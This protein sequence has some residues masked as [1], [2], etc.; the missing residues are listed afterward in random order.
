ML[1]VVAFAYL[2]VPV[3]IFLFSFLSLPFVAISAV[4]LALLVH[5]IYNQRHEFPIS[6]AIKDLG[7]YW[8]LLLMVSVFT[9]FTFSFPLYITWPRTHMLLYELAVNNWSPIVEIGDQS[10]TTRYYVGWYIVPTLLAKLFGIQFLSL[11][12]IL[13]TIVGLFLT[14]VLAFN[15]Y[16]KAKSLLIAGSVFFLLSGLDILMHGGNIS[17]Y[18]SGGASDIDL[19]NRMAIHYPSRLL[20]STP[21][22][23][24]PIALS[25]C[26]YLYHRRLATQ[27]S[28]VIMLFTSMWSTQ[29]ALGLLPIAAWA[30]FKE[31][32]ESWKTVFSWQNLLVAPLLLLPVFLYLTQQ[33]PS[34][35]L[36]FT[37]E[38]EEFS[39]PA[40]LLL[41]IAQFL[42]ILSLLWFFSPQYR[43]LLLVFG[44]FV[45]MPMLVSYGD[46]WNTLIDYLPGSA[47]VIITVLAAKS[48]LEKQSYRSDILLLY[49][50]VAALG[51]AVYFSAKF[52]LHN[53]EFRSKKTAQEF[54]SSMYK[55]EKLL[56]KAGVWKSVPNWEVHFFIKTKNARHV[57]GIPVMRLSDTN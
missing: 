16:N 44:L 35:P 38:W 23:L 18:F 12:A 2:G 5:L 9:V 42:I 41:Y 25:A 40:L 48:Y 21:S 3:F 1:F 22:H 50:L 55:R 11:F 6:P 24:V 15:K 34:I 30:V 54:I 57:L 13:W 17:A 14:L 28:G 53:K 4:A 7:K 27:Y 19:F 33:T 20:G 10:W 29:G 32:K 43:G 49:F 31:G 26:L 37:W 39:L 52:S 51:S 36:L 45:W 56:N 47:L 8:P 46:Y